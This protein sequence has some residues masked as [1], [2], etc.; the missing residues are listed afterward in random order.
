MR[1]EL[2]M[3]YLKIL[4]YTVLCKSN[5]T[6][7]FFIFKRKN[8]RFIQLFIMSVRMCKQVEIKYLKLLPF[9]EI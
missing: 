2:L 9:L 3:K 7:P 5:V 6:S 8:C 1:D 4:S